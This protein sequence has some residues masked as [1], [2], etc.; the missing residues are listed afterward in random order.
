MCIANLNEF[1]IF[2]TSLVFNGTDL[3]LAISQLK[4][5]TELSIPLVVFGHMHKQL[6]FGNELRK[7]IVAGGDDTV[8]LNGA[9][10]PRVQEMG[11]EQGTYNQ[12]TLSDE[13]S[14]KMSQGTLRAFTMV[15]IMNGKLKKVAETWVSVIGENIRIAKEHIMYDREAASH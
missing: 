9:V 6:Q 3:A 1:L 11:N 15:E 13:T 14:V 4:E 12:M 8:Y 5:T 10:V 2:I 7:M